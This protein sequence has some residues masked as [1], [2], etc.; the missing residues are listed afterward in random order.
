MMILVFG[1]FRVVMEKFLQE[2]D[3]FRKFRSVQIFPNSAT[4]PCSD[5]DNSEG[6]DHLES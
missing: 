4:R 5:N 2:T 3:L 1:V 6:A